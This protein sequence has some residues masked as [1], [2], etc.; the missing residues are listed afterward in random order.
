MIPPPEEQLSL[1]DR[2]RLLLEHPHLSLSG[3]RIALSPLNQRVGAVGEN[4]LAIEEEM[5]AASAASVGL[6]VLPEL[7]LS[8][9]PP[10]DLLLRRE[11]TDRLRDEVHRLRE[12]SASLPGL[13]SVVGWA[14]RVGERLYN[15]AAVLRDGEIIASYRKRRLPNYGVFDERRYFTPGELHSSDELFFEHDSRKIALSICEDLWWE[16]SPSSE[17]RMGSPDLVV[18]ISASPYSVGKPAERR[19]MLH[20]RARSIGAPIAYCSISGGQDELVFDGD[21]CVI[22]PDSRDPLVES[23]LFSSDRVILDFSDHSSSSR[24]ASAAISEHPERIETPLNAEGIALGETDDP[25]LTA[26]IYSA[27]R[28]ATRDY[29]TKSGFDSVILG[30]SGGIDSALVAQLAVD[31]LDPDRVRALILPS[32]FSSE[33]TQSDAVSLAIALGITHRVI[34]INPLVSAYEVALSREFEGMRRDVTEE[35]I[36]ARIR[37]TLLMAVSNKTGALL[38]TTGNK[39]EMSVGYSTLYGDMAGGFAPLK[40]L[41]KLWVYR[42]SEWRAS[43]CERMA[44]APQPGFPRSIFTRAPSAE[45]APDQRD[46]DS[47]PP[48]ELLDR[49][50]AAHIERDLSAREIAAELGSEHQETIERVIEMVA[51]AEHKRR[52]AP[53]GPKLSARAFGRDRRFPICSGR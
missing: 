53:P 5:R 35:N 50:L 7:A 33:Q 19:E 18:N 32:E 26:E 51:R 30:L 39:S 47:L 28:M 40:D 45:L 6:L 23:E 11:F 16:G 8:G 15:S 27:L 41:P 4:S 3:L 20:R 24:D 21:S 46:S 22:S 14:E 38:L 2:P 13:A 34:E 52:Q 44:L 42:V 17:I 25:A 37:G 36:Q 10:E 31:A 1:I 49:I 48:Y 12:L 9:Y 43:G 29:I